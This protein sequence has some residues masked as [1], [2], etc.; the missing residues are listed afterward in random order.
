MLLRDKDTLLIFPKADDVSIA[1]RQ[2]PISVAKHQKVRE[3]HAISESQTRAFYLSMHRCH[4]IY[5]IDG[6][7]LLT[8]RG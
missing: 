5:T 8:L 2:N 4:E 7:R 6:D 3:S 1:I